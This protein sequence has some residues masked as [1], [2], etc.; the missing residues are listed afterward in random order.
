MQNFSTFLTESFNMTHLEDLVL[1]DQKN[2]LFALSV[3]DNLI[4]DLS[5][6]SA[7]KVN[8]TVKWDGSPA[9]VYGP[10]PENGRPFIATKGRLL[11][12]EPQVFQSVSDI[13]N[14]DKMPADLAE[15][16]TTVFLNLQKLKIKR[17]LMGDV[18]FTPKMKS[19]QKLDGEA[20]IVFHPNLLAYAVPAKSDLGKKISKAKIG[21]VFHS[22]WSGPDLKG[23]KK[24]VETKIE[25]LGSS[26]DVY[27]DDAEFKELSGKV[28]FTPS[29]VKSFKGFVKSMSSTLRGLDYSLMRTTIRTEFSRYFN[30]NLRKGR[31]PAVTI[32]DI[33]KRS[34]FSKNMQQQIRDNRKAYQDIF[35]AYLTLGN[36]KLQIV[37]RLEEI[38]SFKTFIST[39]KGFEVASPEGFVAIDR[40]GKT[41]KLV[42][43]LTF[44]SNNFKKNFG[45]R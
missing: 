24:K 6:S 42:D 2:A 44:S 38:E 7:K 17:I 36:I 11:R 29:E 9:F 21:V 28:L 10:H 33:L 12:K 32:T 41:V 3:I 20:H 34:R 13:R 8:V 26:P 1:Q 30:Q 15:I 4:D 19:V 39:S 22:S 31:V 14:A 5:G 40:D 23:L 27:Y 35:D 25:N 37:R 45:K 18:L 43:R 16:L